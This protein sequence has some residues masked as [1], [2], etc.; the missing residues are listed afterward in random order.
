MVAKQA[1]AAAPK[2]G[3]EPIVH[4]P[5]SYSRRAPSPIRPHL[6][7]RFRAACYNEDRMPRTIVKPSLV[8]LAA[9]PVLVLLAAIPL[10]AAQTDALLNGLE[11]Q[12][13]VNDFAAVMGPQRVGVDALLTELEQKTGT[14]V[15][16]V[17]LP[18]L[19]GGQQE[20]FAVRLFERW[21]IGRAGEDNGLLILTAI[22][23]RTVRI[24]VG[25]GL[26]PIIPDGLAGRIRDE[27]IIPFFSEE[28]YGEG[29]AS[30]AATV[31]AIVA[32][33]A[34]VELTGSGAGQVA[35]P[36]PQQR[37]RLGRILQIVFFILLIPVLIKNPWLALLLLSGGR[38]GFG[39]GGGFGRGGGGGFGGFGGGMSGGGGASGSW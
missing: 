24:E 36:Q 6:W 29:L 34:G 38:G 5:S 1:R 18:T 13:Y 11:Y 25:Y 22:E 31:A 2:P 21:G 10:A 39:G 33:D 9:I 4:G 7:R 20:D 37:S 17:T 12:G 19:D 32:A 16:I 30:A 14:Q 8:L 35:P 23:D 27:R 15:A 3:G 28:R 26:E